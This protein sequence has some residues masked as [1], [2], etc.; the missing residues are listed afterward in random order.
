MSLRKDEEPET[1]VVGNGGNQINV[2]FVNAPGDEAYN[3]E[4]VLKIG[5]EKSGTIV[6][7]IH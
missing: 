5:K 7:A 1:I 6:I 3:K 4:S 2:D